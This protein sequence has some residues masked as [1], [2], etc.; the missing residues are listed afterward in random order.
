M[1]YSSRVYRHRNP[2]TNEDSKEKP[3]F[4]GPQSQQKGKGRDSFFKAKS[5]IRR[6]AAGPAE[7]KKPDAAGSIK[8]DKEKPVQ[9]KMADQEKE[10][11]ITVPKQGDP[12]KEKETTVQKKGEEENKEIK[13]KS[14][15]PDEKERDKP[16]EMTG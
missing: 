5:I 6:Q 14:Q 10:R 11:E 15:A 2:K 12:L 7:E 3:F 13:R 16:K 9:S 1:S 8:K 4:S